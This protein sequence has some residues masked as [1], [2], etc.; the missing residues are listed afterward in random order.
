VSTKTQRQISVVKKSALSNVPRGLDPATQRFLDEI[1]SE[2]IR[3]S[4][5]A[6]SAMQAIGSMNRARSTVVVETGVTPPPVTSGEG[7]LKQTGWWNFDGGLQVRWGRIPKIKNGGEVRVDFV[8][9]FANECFIVI[10]GGTSNLDGNAK[11]NPVDVYTA[12]DPTTSGF[13]VTQAVDAGSI[14]HYFALGW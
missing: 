14:G 6:A 13:S 1:R 5:I 11:D 8:E 3:V 4:S 2:L 7:S 12:K 10:A 9:K